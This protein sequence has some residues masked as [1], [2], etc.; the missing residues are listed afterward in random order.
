MQITCPQTDYT[1]TL[2][3]HTKPMYGGKLH[4]V[5][6]DIKDNMTSKCLYKMEGEWN[7]KIKFTDEANVSVFGEI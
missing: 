3:F 7:G 1:S 5:T 6:G 2:I 4:R